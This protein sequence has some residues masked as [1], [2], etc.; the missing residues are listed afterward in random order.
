M[1]KILPNTNVIPSAHSVIPSAHSVIPSAVEGSLSTEISINTFFSFIIGKLSKGI[2]LFRFA[3]IGMTMA[4]LLLSP[5]SILADSIPLTVSPARQEISMEPG[6]TSTGILKLINTS[7]SPLSGTLKVVDFIVEDNQGTPVFLEDQNFSS[8]YSATT[9]IKLPYDRLT[10]PANDKIEIQFKINASQNAFPG[11]HYAALIFEAVSGQGQTLTGAPPEGQTLTGAAKAAGSLGYEAEEGSV[12]NKSGAGAS[13]APR[14]A[15]LLYLNIPGD[16]EEMAMV[17]KF[18][19]PKLSQHGPL[20][21]NTSI[22]NQ[23]PT[24]IRPTGII[25]ITN[26]FG[27]ILTH[28]PLE[29]QN[30]F[31]EATR[32]YQNTIP[33][34][35]LFGRY[36]AHLQASYGTQ[37]KSLESIIYFTVIP[38]ALIIY[39]LILLVAII[40]IIKHYTKKNRQHEQELEVE[41]E[42]LKKE[43]NK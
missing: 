39:I 43:L 34:K 8:N 38:I 1:K 5:S 6:E 25:T 33:T 21:I 27:D 18:Y 26:M 32:T 42:K 15:S 28:L 20:D 3:S 23:S 31:P 22:L 37:G 9:W 40:Y 30:I 2:P 7:D 13:I 19:T 41:I 11:G 36:Q 29:E 10:I 4:I 16:Y 12:L 14:I 35:W 17:T 24:H